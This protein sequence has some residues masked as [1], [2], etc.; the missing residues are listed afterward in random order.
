M[1]ENIFHQTSWA[2]SSRGTPI[3]LY[4]KTHSRDRKTTDPIPSAPI[5]F[6]GGV[7]GDEPEG[8]RLAQEFLKWLQK[9]EDEYPEKIRHSWL[10]IPC[11]NAD[12]FLRNERTND[13]GVDLN[14]N[15]PSRDWSPEVKGPRYHPGS[16]AGS[17]AETQAIVR[18]VEMEKPKIIVHF[19]SWEPC[20]VYTGAPGKEASTILAGKTG[21]EVREDIGYPTPGS[22]G[23]YG[24]FDHKIPVI[25]IEE[26]E[27]IHLD[28]VWPHF[29]PGLTQLLTTDFSI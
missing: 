25:C 5:L 19:H 14:R 27:K 29:E 6:I 15:F 18:L 26:Q 1:Q 10:L 16:S 13:K 4:K 11:L 20:V 23:Q 21:Y 17:E 2:R 24:W 9:T 12:G 28:Q 3:E 8:V 7:H 22:L